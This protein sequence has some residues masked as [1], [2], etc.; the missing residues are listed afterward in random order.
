MVM[1]NGS[2]VAS[3]SFQNPLTIQYCAAVM[4]PI[5]LRCCSD[6]APLGFHTLQWLVT[7]MPK[8]ARVCLAGA[9]VSGIGA[10]PTYMRYDAIARI[11]GTIYGTLLEQYRNNIGEMA[12]ETILA[13]R[14]YAK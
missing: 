3:W 13:R 12:I 8:L 1:L 10:S 2:R 5:Q 11:V 4:G 7:G 6:V 9:R 14:N